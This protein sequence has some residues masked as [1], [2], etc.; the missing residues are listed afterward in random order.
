[1]TEKIGKMKCKTIARNK[2]LFTFYTFHFAS[3]ENTIQLQRQD[4]IQEIKT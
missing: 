2:V 4:I 3:F 1:M